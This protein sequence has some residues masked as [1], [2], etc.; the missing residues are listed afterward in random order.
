M[1]ALHG[2]RDEYGS[3]AQPANIARWAARPAQV[4]IFPGAAHMPQRKRPETVV[5]LVALI[6]AL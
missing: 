2:E 5:A 3:A 1:L 4:T 6:Q